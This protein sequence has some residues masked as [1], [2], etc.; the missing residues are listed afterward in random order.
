MQEKLKNC[1]CRMCGSY[2]PSE[3]AKKCHIKCHSL[4]E[5]RVPCQDE[6]SNYCEADHQIDR[7]GILVEEGID[8][9]PSHTVELSIDA[10]SES[11]WMPLIE[12]LAV[13]TICGKLSLCTLNLHFPAEFGFA[14]IVHIC[15]YYSFV[16][17]HNKGHFEFTKHL[18]TMLEIKTL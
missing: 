15:A 10:I 12:N 11:N 13:L 7:D 17:Y 5:S 18:C 1:V 6:A 14:L 4:K 8:D 9:S 16:A 3:A 2:W